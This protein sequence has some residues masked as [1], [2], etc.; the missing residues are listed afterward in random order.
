MKI[1]L[2]MAMTADGM[3]ARDS[4]QLVDWTG[5]ADKKYFVEI[6]RKAGVMIMGS[7]TFD[8]IG[9]VLPGRKNIVMTRNQTKKSNNENLIFTSQS[10]N[11]I[12]TDLQAQGF[13]SVALIGGSIIN[14]LF[15]NE[16]LVDEVHL[17]MVPRLF[18][19]GLALF[20]KPLDKQ[21]A[22]MDVNKLG[23][24]SVLLRYK[25]VS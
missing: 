4:S 19:K 7:K 16:N 17:T 12:I 14:T 5:K 3:I 13:E 2:L 18:G 24:D 8:T 22:L 6:T 15:L 25:V 21:L 1:F 20:N 9:K 11:E 10:P 23:E